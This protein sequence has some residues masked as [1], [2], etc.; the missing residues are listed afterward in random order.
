MKTYKETLAIAT[1]ALMISVPAF[2]DS[3]ALSVGAPPP[4]APIVEEVPAPPGPEYVWHPGHHRW[5]AQ[6]GVYVWVPGHYVRAPHPHA[7]W[8]APAWQQGPRG[9]VFVEGHW[10]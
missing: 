4:P 6:E 8:I 2:A 10:R 5:I 9:W 1:L 7:V 3:F